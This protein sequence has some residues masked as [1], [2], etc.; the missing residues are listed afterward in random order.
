MHT[1]SFHS[2]K[3]LSLKMLPASSI[4]L[5]YTKH[6]FTQICFATE[7]HDYRAIRSSLATR[8]GLMEAS[9]LDLP[10]QFSS[11]SSREGK[12][13]LLGI[14]SKRLD[15]SREP[16]WNTSSQ[17]MRLP[18]ETLFSSKSDLKTGF[19]SLLRSSQVKSGQWK[20]TLSQCPLRHAR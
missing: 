1:P 19:K 5:D 15:S 14:K 2:R 4:W 16:T 13:I 18:M 9:D 11:R 7:A 3:A 6:V 10:S 8:R 20:R 12:T 17:V